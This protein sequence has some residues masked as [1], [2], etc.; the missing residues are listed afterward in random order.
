MGPTVST[1]E[2]LLHHFQFFCSWQWSG[3]ADCDVC[4]LPW[5]QQG[6]SLGFHSHFWKQGHKNQCPVST[7]EFQKILCEYLQ[8]FVAKCSLLAHYVLLARLFQ[9]QQMFVWKADVAQWLLSG[10]ILVS[11]KAGIVFHWSVLPGWPSAKWLSENVLGRNCSQC[12]NDY[13]THLVLICLKFWGYANVPKMPHSMTKKSF[14]STFIN[15]CVLQR[16]LRYWH[17]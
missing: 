11:I 10:H 1:N 3:P 12:D 8:C 15:I 9:C 4:W 14:T 17:K 7:R 2:W 5:Q 13:I 6:G 16:C